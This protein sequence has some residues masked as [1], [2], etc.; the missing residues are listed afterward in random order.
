MKIKNN[1]LLDMP[2]DPAYERDYSWC[3]KCGAPKWN[4]WPKGTTGDE[5]FEKFEHCETCDCNIGWHDGNP[6]KVHAEKQPP[7]WHCR[8]LVGIEDTQSDIERY[9]IGTIL[10]LLDS[11][12]NQIDA[13]GDECEPLR[14]NRDLLTI[15]KSLSNCRGALVRLIEAR[16]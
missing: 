4:Q 9:W 8:K 13:A 7:G 12:I 6:N 14:S 10:N 16:S 1:P 5:R 2:N 15:D 11:T 3:Y